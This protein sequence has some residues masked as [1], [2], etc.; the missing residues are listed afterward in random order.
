MQ[1]REQKIL[2]ILNHGKLLLKE[3]AKELGVSEM[4]L[5]RDLH[6][7]E[8]R[9]LLIQVKGGAVPYPHILEPKSGAGQDSPI[10]ESIA[11][12]AYRKI[13]PCKTLY[14]GSGTTV[15]AFAKQ[16]LAGEVEHITVITNSLPAAAI[17]FQSHHQVILLGGELRSD[18]LDLIGAAAERSI[19]NYFVDWLIMGCDSVSLEDGFYTADAG[20]A[21]LEI[22]S[23]KI[24]Q[25]VALVTE[26]SK[27]GR[28]SFAKFANMQDIDL[29]VTDDQLP[30]SQCQIL[31]DNG[32]DVVRVPSV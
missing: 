24:A 19:E 18:S 29:L 4:T 30:D 13:M 26:S 25:H 11:A 32:I 16:L 17:L 6:N 12:A 8:A 28:R 20:M 22:K 31:V 21:N 3:T 1:N 9:K 23:I 14:L 10:K 27:F 7:L 2:S 5:R 15:K